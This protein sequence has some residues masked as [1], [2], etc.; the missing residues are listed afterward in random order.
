MCARL[1]LV[2]ATSPQYTASGLAV[3]GPRGDLEKK[4]T[5]A[6]FPGF[7]PSVLLPW[8]RLTWPCLPPG[9]RTAWII[10]AGSKIIAFTNALQPCDARVCNNVVI[11]AL[12]D[13]RERAAWGKRPL[14]I[15]NGGGGGGTFTE[16]IY[17]HDGGGWP[18]TTTLPTPCAGTLT[19][20]GPGLIQTAALSS[21]YV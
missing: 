19:N 11:A 21:T 7:Q 4:W 9:D 1:P 20:R 3:Q 18:Q 2:R 15:N 5:P 13:P 14:V 16:N 12:V 6:E 10:E 17:E 8:H